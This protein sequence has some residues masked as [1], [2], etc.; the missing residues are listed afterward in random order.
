MR[1]PQDKICALWWTGSSGGD[2]VSA[3]SAGEHEEDKE[4]RIG[5]RRINIAIGEAFFSS[6]VTFE[7]LRV[8]S[9]MVIA[10]I[11]HDNLRTQVITIVIADGQ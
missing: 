11:V 10:I 2:T 5:N 7:E 6:D 3:A 4:G 1:F 9:C 8:V